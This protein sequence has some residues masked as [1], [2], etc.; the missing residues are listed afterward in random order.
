MIV[1]H[2][3]HSINLKYTIDETEQIVN[4]EC[5]VFNVYPFPEMKFL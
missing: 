3:Q 2:P 5:S 1:I 4:F